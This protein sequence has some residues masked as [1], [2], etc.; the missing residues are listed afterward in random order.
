ML[1]DIQ[2]TLYEFFGYLAPGLIFILSLA[3][4]TW[5]IFNPDFPLDLDPDLSAFQIIAIIF[6]SYLFGHFVQAISNRIERWNFFK[7]RVLNITGIPEPMFKQVKKEVSKIF[8]KGDLGSIDNY[9]IYKFCDYYVLTKKGKCE[10]RDIYNYRIGFYRGMATAFFFL[11]ISLIIRILR[12]PIILNLPS[13][14][15]ISS[16]FKTLFPFESQEIKNIN[17]FFMIGLL[18]MCA[19]FV[20]LFYKRLAHFTEYRRQ[21][22]LY[23]FIALNDS[24]KNSPNFKND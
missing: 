8:E 9:D 2:V 21:L 22:T 24:E 3:I 4:T 16:L 7:R 17:Q 18:A 13:T 11:S 20:W 12:G 15:G 6:F 10:E 1:K 14:D 19:L 23:G 5:A